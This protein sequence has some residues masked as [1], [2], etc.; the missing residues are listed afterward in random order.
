MKR[1]NLN[2]LVG[3]VFWTKVYGRRGWVCREVKIIRSA[4]HSVSHRTHEGV[5]CSGKDK[6][7]IIW[8]IPERLLFRTRREVK[9]L[10][11]RNG[12]YVYWHNVRIN[13][14]QAT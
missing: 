6:G 13:R 11:I 3:Q 4:Q 7:G 5:V 14:G 8:N 9:K 10:L 12:K 1:S 2:E